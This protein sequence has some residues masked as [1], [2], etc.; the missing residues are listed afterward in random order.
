MPALLRQRRWW[1]FWL[2]VATVA[3]VCVLLSRWQWHRYELRQGQ[4]LQLDTAL[5]A[6]AVPLDEVLAPGQAM[7][8]DLQFRNVSVTGYFD[9][10]RTAAVRGHPMNGKTGFWVVTPLVTREGTVLVNRGWTATTG[11]ARSTPTLPTPPAGQVSVRGHLRLPESARSQ[12]TPPPG[13]GWAV[14]PRQ[15][16]VGDPAPAFAAYVQLADS[17]QPGSEGLAAL[18]LPGHRGTNNLVYSVQWIL[19]GLVAVVGGWRLMAANRHTTDD[20]VGG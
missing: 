19:F 16:L 8:A 18:A 4:N 6:P 13:Q 15:L 20:M 1:T 17:E 14:D 3:V 7:P 10:S 9:D 2:L 5:S 11:D 12:G